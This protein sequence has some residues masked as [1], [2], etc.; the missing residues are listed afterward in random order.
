MYLCMGERK[1]LKA[2]GL[3]S[4]L[5]CRSSVKKLTEIAYAVGRSRPTALSAEEMQAVEDLLGAH[6]FHNFTLYS[7]ILINKQLICSKQIHATKRNS[8]T[9]CFTNPM[10]AHQVCY[11]TVEKLLT[12]C[13]DSDDCVHVIAFVKPFQ[14][15]RS[16]VVLEASLSTCHP[17]IQPYIKT[18]VSDFVTINDNANI[19]A[20]HIDHISLKCFDLSTVDY[21]GLTNLVNESEVIL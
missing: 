19:I 6:D 18:L 5:Y 9:V 3:F 21:Q 12:L 4:T 20:I 2:N 8:Y 11:G 13:V 7:K 17:L 10:M 15:V 14:A 1:K 16:C